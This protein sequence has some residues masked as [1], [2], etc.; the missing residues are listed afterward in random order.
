MK[1]REGMRKRK[2]WAS[3]KIT[4]RERVTPV[5]GWMCPQYNKNKEWTIIDALFWPERVNIYEKTGGVSGKSMGKIAYTCAQR[6][7]NPLPLTI[8]CTCVWAI[9][10]PPSGL[11]LFDL[12]SVVTKLFS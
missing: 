9:S 4:V 10:L 3:I 7:C 8:V 5:V 12:S 6:R 1:E 2:G 11:G